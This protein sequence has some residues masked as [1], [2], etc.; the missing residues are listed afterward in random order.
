M[1]FV[2]KIKKYTNKVMESQEKTQVSMEMFFP[3]YPEKNF[4]KVFE[5]NDLNVVNKLKEFTDYRLSATETLPVS[6]GIPTK[7]QIIIKH[8]L[9]GYTRFD[10]LVL[11]HEMGTG[12]TCSAI[13]AIEQ[14]IR[15]SQDLFNKKED[16]G[17]E[18]PAIGGPGLTGAIIITRGKTLMN[19]FQEELV[20]KCTPG[21]YNPDTGTGG[22]SGEKVSKASK[23]L[24]S[25]FYT[26]FTY[27]VFAKTIKS[28]SKGEILKNFDN[29]IIVIDEAHNLRTTTPYEQPLDDDGDLLKVNEKLN[30]YGE[31]HKFIHL[32]KNKKVILLTGTP[33][34]DSPEEIAPLM[35]LVLPLDQQ[36]P[37]H[38]E[39][40]NIF[41]P[42]SSAFPFRE[43]SASVPTNH[44]MQ[45]KEKLKEGVYGYISFL[46]AMD[47]TVKKVNV[48][49]TMGSLKYYKIV[50]SY[51]LPFQNEIYKEAYTKD[52][53][54]RGIYIHSRQASRLVFP[55]GTYGSN[56]FSR[57]II[58]PRKSGGSFKLKQ[59][60]LKYLLGKRFN[61]NTMGIIG[62][63]RGERERNEEILAN[64]KRISAKY[65]YI[66]RS[67]MEATEKGENSIVYDDAVKGSGLIVL[68][69]LLELFGFVRNFGKK[70]QNPKLGGSKRKMYAIFTN[71]TTNVNEISVLKNIFNSNRNMNGDVISVI[72]G[73]RV[74]AEG[75]TFK[76][77][78]HE[79]VVPHWNDSET[80]QV[81]YRG[82][83]LGSHEALL[84]K[85]RDEGGIG[86]KPQLNIYRHAVLPLYS[87]SRGVT[88]PSIDLEM[89]EISENKDLEISQV[90]RCL[91]EAALDCYLFK[92][93]NEKDSSFDNQK[94]CE[95]EK[96]EYKCDNDGPIA[97]SPKNDQVIYFVEKRQKMF[98]LLTNH[99]KN[100]FVSTFE[101][102]SQF[103]QLG[104]YWDLIAIP[105]KIEI[106]E[107]LQELVNNNIPIENVYGY[108]CYLYEN[109]NV[110]YLSDHIIPFSSSDDIF[111]S[112]YSKH[113]QLWVK[114]TKK[115]RVSYEDQTTW[116]NTVLNNS[117][118]SLIPDAI[119]DLSN[120]KNKS[121]IEQKLLALPNPIQQRL[122]EAAVSARILESLEEG[123]VI[124]GK[125]KF[126]AILLNYYKNYFKIYA[127]CDKTKTFKLAIVWFL[128]NIVEER[129][130]ERCLYATALKSKRP[131]WTEWKTCNKPERELVEQ[132]REQM[133]SKYE[134]ALGY[135]GL[136]NPKLKEFCIRDLTAKTQTKTGDK[137]SIQSG[138]RCVNWTKP[139]L[140]RL[141]AI[142]T[143]V[144]IDIK[145]APSFKDSLNIVEDNKLLLGLLPGKTTVGVDKDTIIRMAYWFGHAR[146]DICDSLQ[147][148]F[149]ENKLLV[150]DYS[151]GVQTKKK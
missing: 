32:L 62:K 2:I 59:P 28:M 101:E 16:Q 143:S 137:R 57:N 117:L 79:H 91:K 5:K 4:N 53:N 84:K 66:L 142:I 58:E 34:K 12:K 139:E 119:T 72:F 51:M 89:Y 90:L 68:T 38:N 11:V 132:E 105:S 41:F 141:A 102:I 114:V 36:L 22:S 27:E 3:L 48:G 87:T 19:N 65:E 97:F 77:V 106:L 92:Q 64:I 23:K 134:T 103:L 26:F 31:V 15:E 111:L 88:S 120:T 14:N 100:R 30:I 115:T 54:E 85:W 8:L 148:W 49:E 135:Y 124:V 86:P 17:I 74:I 82:W 25:K 149:S 145:T 147:E 126:R 93:R 52:K 138:K 136:W 13:Q 109:K 33:M 67:I 35:N 43:K 60:F 129:A 94:E 56:G 83:R 71:E 123:N 131:L 122:L 112:Y 24:I 47:S 29:K 125:E 39:F 140:T 127:D 110:Y 55:D 151:C 128:A 69:L 37:T 50:P 6:P 121:E 7:H 107:L 76:N 95:Y 116:F 18:K 98:K 21:Q 45:N 42:S 133:K 70:V 20:F 130:K 104:H 63:E 80:S 61:E 10:A 96:C 81:I 9:S 118:D 108:P 146:K 40:R 78:I 46:K 144:P 73:S 75:L 99:Y 113:P 1:A 150:E 44:I